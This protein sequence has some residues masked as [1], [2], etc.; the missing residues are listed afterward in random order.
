M[1]TLRLILL[2]A[3]P[4][5]LALAGCTDSALLNES[6]S[7]VYYP[8]ENAA[9]GGNL[10]VFVFGSPFGESADQFSGQVIDAMQGWAF[11]YPTHFVSAGDTPPSAY[12]AAMVFDAKPF[13]PEICASPLTRSET[14]AQIPGAGA[15]A[16][17]AAAP[18][19]AS[20]SNP[21]PSR[22]PLTAVLCRGDTYMAWLD[23][24]VPAGNGPESPAFRRGIGQ[25]TA[26][27]FPTV[28]PDRK[29]GNGGSSQ[30]R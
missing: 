5:L 7:R 20:A 23:G 6:Y 28:N 30:I 26:S 25:F 3:V 8:G 14:S 16:A 9:A 10:P 27:L 18:P 19:A 4:G 29:E 12:R 24:S 1:S 17:P 15:G 2:S 21:P 22:I 11:A 13:G